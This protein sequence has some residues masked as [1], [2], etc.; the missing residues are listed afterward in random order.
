MATIKQTKAAEASEAPAK[1][2]ASNP[3]VLALSD[4]RAV[5]F[6]KPKGSKSLLIYEILG[7][8]NAAN[9]MLIAHYRA[10]FHVTS[11]DGKAV[12]P[13]VTK[14]QVDALAQRLGDDGLDEVLVHYLTHFQ[15]TKET[16]APLSE[17]P[18]DEAS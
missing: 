1:A 5:G 13:A 12:M 9:N 16:I 8:V 2:P 3:A 7:P 15:A 6:E 18:S 11:I 14:S 10:L 4:G 17:T